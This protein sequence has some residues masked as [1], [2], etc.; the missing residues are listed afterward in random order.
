M[1][2]FWKVI[3]PE[4]ICLGVVAAFTIGVLVFAIIVLGLLRVIEWLGGIKIIG[5]M[6]RSLRER[7]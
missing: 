4:M 1:G 5:P 6:I 2:D 7:R 3:E